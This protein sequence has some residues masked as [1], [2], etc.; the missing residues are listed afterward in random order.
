MKDTDKDKIKTLALL[1]RKVAHLEGFMDAKCHATS[2][3]KL[4]SYY[5]DYCWAWTETL[6][7]MQ[8][9]LER[10]LEESNGKENAPNG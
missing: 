1:I 3:T 5:S 8:E 6:S 7:S 10:T 9:E 4:L 2:D